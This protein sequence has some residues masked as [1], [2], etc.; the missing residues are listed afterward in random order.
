LFSLPN[1]TETMASK[2]S[3]RAN[4]SLPAPVAKK[5][6]DSPTEGSQTSPKKAPAKKDVGESAKHESVFANILLALENAE[7]LP[8]RCREMLVAMVEPSLSAPRSE[9]HATQVLGVSMIAETLQELR[10][11]QLLVVEQAQE[12]LL[13]LQECQK[14][15]MAHV[16]EAQAD[17]ASKE[18]MEKSKRCTHMEASNLVSEGETTVAAAKEAVRKGDEP[19]ALLEAEKAAL[20]RISEEHVKAP[21]EAGEG[22]HY[23]E[24][25]PH[26]QK[27]GL[28]ESLAIALPSSCAKSK[29]QRGGFDDVV[30]GELDKA[31]VG[32]IAAL[33]K[34]I[35]E[36]I[37]KADERKAV[38]ISEESAMEGKV[39]AAKVAALELENAK[40]ACQESSSMLSKVTEELEAH[41]PSVREAAS[42]L[43]ELQTCLYNF[44]DGPL[45]T[46]QLY[47]NKSAPNEEAAI[48]GA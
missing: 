36:E 32:K 33:A 37:P 29:E 24:L 12:E 21:M 9:R 19:F 3:K 46:F 13:K 44:E 25:E 5:M 22:P 28:D 2:G 47:Q 6:K 41:A 18:A 26:I 10:A 20:V 11:R 15:R 39:A 35:A 40:V 8:A 27:L 14:Q 17:L 48:A 45:A 1:I 16:S 7:Y 23:N 42:K 31:L 38:V 43:L 34:S 30:L 4:S